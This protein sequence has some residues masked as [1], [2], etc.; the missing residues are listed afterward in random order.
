MAG[1]HTL[2]NLLACRNG[3][4]NNRIGLDTPDCPKF[5]ELTLAKLITF[6]IIMATTMP[7]WTC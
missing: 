1:V 4:G 7:V 2:P 6:H 5:Y 3:A